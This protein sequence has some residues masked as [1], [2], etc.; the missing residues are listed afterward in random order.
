MRLFKGFYYS[1]GR[2]SED[3]LIPL[4]KK[5]K[6]DSV[7]GRLKRTLSESDSKDNS[8]SRLFQIKELLESEKEKLGSEEKERLN[9]FE[10]L[11]TILKSEYTLWHKSE[12]GYKTDKFSE[13][14]VD[15]FIRRIDEDINGYDFFKEILGSLTPNFME[16]NS[17]TAISRRISQIIKNAIET[18]LPKSIK[19]LAEESNTQIEYIMIKMETDYLSSK[20]VEVSIQETNYSTISP[21]INTDKILKDISK[22]LG[23]IL[24][25]L[26]KDLLKNIAKKD[27]RTGANNLLKEQITKPIVK[28]IRRLLQTEAKKVAAKKAAEA[29]VKGGMG[30]IGWLML[31]Y[32]VLS[33]GKDLHNMYKEMKVSLKNTLKNEESFR[34]IFEEE[35]KRVSSII[36][37]EVVKELNHNFSKEK[38]DET[39]I[40]DGIVA[41]DNVLFELKKFGG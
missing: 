2:F 20:N 29:G 22:L 3:Y 16:R 36:I 11:S 35:A 5:S 39:Y 25:K 6:Y 21:N 38:K 12:I 14:L 26:L 24:K 40:L 13:E 28:L 4:S 1:F 9:T 31:V 33:I 8:I 34:N 15:I 41:C 37:D 17:E 32:D 27:L 7:F 30:P 10:N 23:P 19:D 18:V